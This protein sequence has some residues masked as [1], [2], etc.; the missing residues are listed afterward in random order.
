MNTFHSPNFSSRVQEL[1]QQHHVPGISIALIHDDKVAS[2]GYGHASL[3]PPTACTAD[4]LFDIASSSKSLTAASVALLIDDGE[5]Y[6]EVQWDALMSSL[7]PDDFVMSSEEYTGGVTVED[8][9]SHRSGLPG[10]DDSYMGI[11]AAQPDDARSITRNLRNLPVAAPIRSKYMYCNMMYTVAT[12]LVESKS[13]ERFPD[14]LEHHFFQ[15]LEMNSTNLQPSR[16]CH[17]GLGDRLAMGHSWDDETSTYRSFP[18]TDCPEGQGAGSIIT[19]AN[20]Y[21]K[22]VKA[23]LYKE[24]PITEAMYSGVTKPRTIQDPDGKN[25]EPFSSPILYAAGWEVFYYRGYAVIGHDGSVPGFGSRHFFLPEFNFGAVVLGNSDSAALVT[26]IIARELIDEL[27]GVP[28]TERPDWNE[29]ISRNA[30]ENPDEEEEFRQQL[31]PGIQQAEPQTLSLAAYTGEYSHPGYHTLKVE[32]TEEELFI[33]A[34]DRSFGFTMTFDHVCQQTKFIAHL[35]DPLGG[36]D[37]PLKV[38]FKLE[39]DK[40]VRM[41]VHF[42]VDLEDYIWFD[43]V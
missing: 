18:A 28:A 32:V 10:H 20:D 26:S 21:I 25:M 43:K 22:W 13:G 16:A 15:P 3:D 34:M 36:E 42:E 29:T 6:P 14:Y 9:L 2:A 35:H 7:L 30:E 17:K 8:I 41:G 24:G 39:G 23:M 33:D 31:C 12:H 27:L 38:E 19:S 1:M 5:R 4:T 11:R 40:A 37:I